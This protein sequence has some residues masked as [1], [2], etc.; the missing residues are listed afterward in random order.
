MA[1]K[2]YA[3]RIHNGGTQKVDALFNGKKPKSGTVK[4]GSDLRTK[5]GK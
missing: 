1:E 2:T 4:T 5:G 3:G